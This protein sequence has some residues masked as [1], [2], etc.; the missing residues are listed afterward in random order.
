MSDPGMR[1]YD[2]AAH[3][4]SQW[5]RAKAAPVLWETFCRR[6]I[7]WDCLLKHSGSSPGTRLAASLLC[8]PVRLVSA[9][10]SHN[11]SRLWL[12]ST[13]PPVVW[14]RSGAAYHGRGW[15]LKPLGW[16]SVSVAEKMN[17][18][19]NLGFG[20]EIVQDAI[21]EVRLHCA[22][23]PISCTDPLPFVH[24]V[25]LEYRG[26]SFTCMFEQ[27][28]F[29]FVDRRVAPTRAG[30]PLPTQGRATWGWLETPFWT[31]REG[32]FR[33]MPHVKVWVDFRYSCVW[34]G[35]SVRTDAATRCSGECR[36]ALLS[37]SQFSLA[38]RDWVSPIPAVLDRGACCDR[39]GA[40]PFGCWRLW[41][42]GEMWCSSFRI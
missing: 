27:T 3:F 21:Q 39:R 16:F 1:R 8:T 24:S 37:M 38:G 13:F 7:Y 2:W 19:G 15:T 36:R 25:L 6:V 33:K 11:P 30:Q 22:P 41:R 23:G 5:L 26:F 35:C 10:L 14:R 18:Q 17:I 29:C 9:L 40:A 28:R 31:N 20:C 32:S 34:F 4:T 42:E 12:V